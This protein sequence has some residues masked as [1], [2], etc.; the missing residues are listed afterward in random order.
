MRFSL[1]A[2]TSTLK[3]HKVKTVFISMQLVA[4]TFM[5][6]FEYGDVIYIH[7]SLQCLQALDTVYHRA[8]RL[9]GNLQALTHHLNSFLCPLALKHWNILSYTSLL[10]QLPSYLQS[11]IHKK[12][13]QKLAVLVLMNYAC[14]LSSMF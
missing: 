1:Y 5:S 11:Y 9:L 10:G 14:Y 12:T 8:L 2:H 4:A 6:L 13:V 7:A 3:S